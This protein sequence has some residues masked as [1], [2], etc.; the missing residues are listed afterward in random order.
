[1]A[2]A[3]IHLVQ[4]VIVLNLLGLIVAVAVVMAMGLRRDKSSYTGVRNY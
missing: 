3:P 1:M 2:Y 4:F